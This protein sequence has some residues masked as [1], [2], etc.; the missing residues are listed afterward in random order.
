MT[1]D[2]VRRRARSFAFGPFVLV[3]GRQ[4]LSKDDAP[5][6]IGG[7]AL[8]ILT[9][10]VERPGELVSKRELLS[11]TWPD[12]VVEESNLKVNIAALRRVLG[13][14]TEH[15]IATVVGRGYRFVAP[16]QALVASAP[17][18]DLPM[19]PGHNL[20]IGTARIVGRAETIGM[21]EHE[22]DESRLVSIVGAG[23]I[24]K[25]TVALAVAERVVATCRDGVWFVDLAPLTDA[26][27]VPNAIA[28]AVGLAAHSANMLAALCEYLRGREMLLVLDSCEHLVESAATCASRILA[29]VEGV[30]ILATSREPLRVKGERVRRLPG[31]AMPPASRGL[32]A[33]DALTFPAIELF[34]DRARERLESFRL[35]D[36][37][38]PVVAEICRRLDGLALAIELAATRVDAFDVGEM[39]QQ[40]ENRFGLLKGHRGSVERHRT[41]TATIDWSYELLSDGERSLMRRLA[42]FA[43]GF[44]LASACAVA[45][46]EAPSR[47]N[48]VEDLASLVA[49]SLV[50]A[51][52]RDGGMEYRLLDTTRSYALEKLADGNETA[53][54]RRQHAQHLLDLA[55]QAG[56]DANTLPRDAWL[57]RY[58]ARIDDLRNA[59]AWAFDDDVSVPLGIA[60]TV[61]A[62]AFWEQLSLLEE[63]RVAVERALERRFD[64]HRDERQTQALY[65]ALGAS[66]LYTRG[67]L[68]EVKSAL[69]KALEI[70]A[71][72]RDTDSQLECLRGLSEYE[73]WTGNT[74]SALSASDAMR[75]IAT[76]SGDAK[77]GENADAQAGSALRYLGDLAASQ[78]HLER[79]VE[80]PMRQGGRS[81]ASRFEFDQ[82]LA[83]RG[84]LAS[85]LWLRGY[86][87][88]AVAM[89]IRQREEAE[90]SYHA[91]PVCSAII[92][93]TL[94][95][96]LF[97]GDVDGAQKLLQFIENYTTEHR[98]TVWRAMATCMRGRWLLDCG[99][100][101]ELA[102]FRAAVTELYDHGL[103]MRYPSYLA[104]LGEGLAQLGD[105]DGAHASTDKALAVSQSSGQVW[106]MSEIL[107]MK[108]NLLRK[109]GK[110]GSREAAAAHYRESL[111]WAREQGA[112]SWE[113]R[114]AVSLVELGREAGGDDEAERILASTYPRFDEGFQTRDLLR[115]RT[116]L[117]DARCR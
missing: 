62:I 82:R 107:R 73:L 48:V 81:D 114:T 37:G 42:T 77:A 59:L 22:L 15:Y 45:S 23:G 56:A 12:T 5:V 8:D 2:L 6:R 84:S 110:P 31:L 33:S 102:P 104:N 115:A 67:P 61:A 105:L 57:G 98:L 60:L 101:F 28:T 93:T 36:A 40:L 91:V 49:K 66:L 65:L 29:D 34:V 83:A 19:S 30:K 96:A 52:P 94:S 106:G 26:S 17:D 39:L 79:I 35:D 63:C 117:A 32:R 54:A 88:Q 103:R 18:A 75:S 9:V 111:R 27:L 58:V 50:A 76:A 86:P 72:I 55:R 92:H 95:I 10:L 80:R 99:K 53:N 14:G 68:P 16:V 11:R 116:L 1:D 4:R 13:E 109:D 87:D 3:P 112:L 100:P 85:V 97:V 44:G 78:A 21:I 71:R 108:G 74:R 38:A 51:E 89:A 46:G 25:T 113:L 69:T 7:R 20:P 43:G 41:L 70:A 90:A 47:A 24:G 64:A